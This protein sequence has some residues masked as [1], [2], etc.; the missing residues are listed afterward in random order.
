MS[1][2]LRNL[3]YQCEKSGQLQNGGESQSQLFPPCK[4]KITFCNSAGSMEENGPW[5]ALA[6]DEL[7]NTMGKDIPDLK[8]AFNK[9]FI[10]IMIY[11]HQAWTSQYSISPLR[12]LWR[13]S[14]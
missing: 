1:R 2:I 12:K 10:I 5:T 8:F 3:K 9:A 7:A 13:S 11:D 14:S 6:E 4:M